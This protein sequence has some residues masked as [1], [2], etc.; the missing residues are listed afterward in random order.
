MTSWA[1]QQGNIPPTGAQGGNSAQGM[2]PVS[3]GNENLSTA[4][5]VVPLTGA[6]DFGPGSSGGGHSYLLPAFIWTGF[7]DTGINGQPG[8]SNVETRSVYLGNLTLERLKSHSQ[9]DLD[10]AGG[11]SF[12]SK[13]L[14]ASHAAPPPSY[15]TLVQAK[16][17]E[18]LDWRRWQ[19]LLSDQVM[20]LPES[21]FGFSGFG[22]LNSFAGGLGGG[23]LGNQPNLNPTLL[24]NQSIL[25]GNS[26]RVANTAVAEVAYHPGARSEI[27][28][29]GLYGLLNFLDPGFVDNNYW[30]LLAGYN[31]Q[32]NRRDEFGI[33]YSHYLYKFSG[34]NFELLDRGFQLFYRH[35]LTGKL[36]LE[37]AAG[38]TLNQI[39][40]P[41]GA[42]VVA[43]G[44]WSTFD[45]LKYRA[46]RTNAEL[47]F[48]RYLSGGGGVLLGA[49]SDMARLTVGR[50][51]ARRF[52]GS[53][54]F[55][56]V[57]NQ[58][59]VQQTSVQR[60]TK[61]E[62]WE[63]GFNFSREVGERLSF[64]LNY[65]AQRQTTNN[66]LCFTADC[67]T[68]HLRQVGGIGI[69]WHGRPIGLR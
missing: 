20:Y 66:S 4:V 27:T 58:S 53:L 24:P 52:R 5:P 29:T 68:V 7:A 44:F 55:G 33:N 21:A 1:Q 38:P 56:H 17:S 42:G 30:G 64:Y 18:T 22:G 65:N 10:L 2:N 45:S 60:R 14:R 28:V 47:T 48:A 16:L 35:Q 36:S 39:A 41:L 37:I 59:L 23:A 67:G 51:L 62:T 8:F 13:S 54:D 19:V 12:Y 31:Y 3:A 11:A 6:R 69:N 26:R 15:G 43:R 34:S 9:T 32:L 50:Q 57:F 61:Y 63:A 46:G 49:E 40:Q 25:T